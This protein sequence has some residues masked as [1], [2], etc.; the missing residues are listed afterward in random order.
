MT[1]TVQGVFLLKDN[2]FADAQV[3]EAVEAE[4]GIAVQRAVGQ[5]LHDH[6]HGKHRLAVNDMGAEEWV[7][8][9]ASG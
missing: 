9:D 5:P 8:V 1:R 3:V 4:A 2:P 7:V 6:G